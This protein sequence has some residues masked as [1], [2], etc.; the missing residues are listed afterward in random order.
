LSGFVGWNLLAQDMLQCEAKGKC[1]FLG[2]Y[3][4]KQ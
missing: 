4:V 2:W 3:D 1:E